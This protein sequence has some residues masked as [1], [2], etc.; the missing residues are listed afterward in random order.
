MTKK[1]NLKRW[2]KF[3]FRKDVQENMS[4]WATA[5]FDY[6]PGKVLLDCLKKKLD[7]N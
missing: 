6:S 4:A 5:W 1:E 7:T 3:M 2:E